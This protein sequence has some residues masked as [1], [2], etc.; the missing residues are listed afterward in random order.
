MEGRLLLKDCTLLDGGQLRSHQAVVV[1]GP[2][3]SR[4]A[5]DASE[6]V[7]PGDWA[8]D[9]RGRLLLP[10]RIDAHALVPGLGDGRRAPTPAEVEALSLGAIAAALRAGLTCAMAQLPS[11]GD[12]AANLAA[13]ARAARRLG[14]R[15]L[16]SVAGEGVHAVAT[17][18]VNLAGAAATREDPLVRHGL[19]FADALSASDE[20]LRVVGRDS[21]RLRVPVQFR[22]AESDSQL[23]DHFELH[24][25]RIVERLDRH[26]LLGPSTIAAHARAVEGAEAALLASRSVVIA[27]SPLADLLGELH[28]FASVW[29]PEHRVALASG[30]AG[31]LAAQWTAARTLA[32]RAARLGRLWAEERLLELL[33]GIGAAEL[34]GQLFGHPVAEIAPGALADLV[35]LDQVPGEGASLESAL[36]RSVEAPVSWTVVH[37]RV[38]VREGQLLGADLVELL[39]EAA[40]ARR[41]LA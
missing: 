36:H 19:G 14:F 29:L 8:I 37:G 17:H 22:L 9:A 5:P 39:A 6:P 33:R 15:L 16:S 21:Q 13:Q 35:V 31:G 28:G 10:G 7:R 27:W 2:L 30:G 11:G 20:L 4:V 26:G 34:L 41:A 3:V 12:A 38:V 40:A 25:R 24:H 32:H 18:D 23:A 1:E